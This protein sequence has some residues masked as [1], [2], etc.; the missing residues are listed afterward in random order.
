MI[1]EAVL[2]IFGLIQ[3]VDVILTKFDLWDLVQRWGSNSDS[4]LMFQ[5]TSCRF[6]LW[7]HLGWI[8]TVVFGIFTG[9]EWWL[10]VV[11]FIVS[12]LTSLI[13]KPNHDS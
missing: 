13:S 10:L 3:F 9:F 4:E 1:L 11:P 2:I 8:L 6:C 7:F 12:G 5:L